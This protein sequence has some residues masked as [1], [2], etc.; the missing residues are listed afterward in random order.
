MAR[1]ETYP[2]DNNIQD[3]DIVLGSDGD[4]NSKTKNYKVGDL[5]SYL[6][7]F[8]NLQPA[9][10]TPPQTGTF[11]IDLSN[12]LSTDYSGS[13]T[14]L[15]NIDIA[16]GAVQGGNARIKGNWS[17]QPTITGATEA[18]NS[19][20]VADTVIYLYIEKWADGVIYWYTED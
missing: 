13:T 12:Y 4:D 18:S 5:V 11:S 10:A 14:S 16:S 9:T 3:N 7:N 6:L 17:T 19:Q 15:L 1:I 8:P 20:F 2:E